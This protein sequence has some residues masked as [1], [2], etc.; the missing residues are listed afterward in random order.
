MLIVAGCESAAVH[1]GNAHGGE[2]IRADAVSPRTLAVLAEVE[3]ADGTETVAALRVCDESLGGERGRLDAGK[4]DHLLFDPVVERDAERGGIGGT[5]R[6][7]L[8]QKDV[9]GVEAEIDCAE[10]QEGAEK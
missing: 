4:G 8:E 9:L 1:H 10:I 6:V 2:E 3:R 5:G 7:K